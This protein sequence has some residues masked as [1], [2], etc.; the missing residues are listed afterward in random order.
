MVVH[1]ADLTHGVKLP[2]LAAE[3]EAAGSRVR[4]VHVLG[5]HVR[6]AALVHGASL[7]LRLGRL[8]PSLLLV[9]L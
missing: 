9:I 3:V 6:P 5:V 2:D 4:A 8:A 1:A 7:E